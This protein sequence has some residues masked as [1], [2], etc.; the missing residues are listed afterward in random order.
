MKTFLFIF[1]CITLTSCKFENKPQ[2]SFFEFVSES[3]TTCLKEI[4]EAKK[5]LENGKLTY[6]H[7]SGNIINHYLRSE[8]E[9]IEVLKENNIDFRNEGSSC[10][11]YENQTEHCYCELMEEK[12]NQKYGE[13]F[14][15]SLLNIADEK[16]LIKH[17][18]DTMHY[19]KCDRRPNY[20]NDKDDSEDEYSEVM[21]KE[22][23]DAINYPKGY[24]KRPNYDVSAFVNI[25]FY[26][27]K[28]G[29]AKITYFSFYFDIKS[30][31][32]LEKHF[33]S[34]L[35][36]IIKREKWKP[37]QMRKRNVNSDMVLRY[38]FE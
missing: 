22:I 9:L 2:G 30:N 25:S 36:K 37:A 29:N 16:Y 8:K 33:E 4:A 5:E 13:K 10:V 17:I 18:N 26:V 12:I 14:V 3:D 28:N 24:I 27:D 6:C 35:K 1:L 38:G 21:Q 15:D 23:D 31:H 20:P 32:K 34:E 7:Y 11:V 19:A